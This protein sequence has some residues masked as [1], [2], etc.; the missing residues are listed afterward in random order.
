[1]NATQPLAA[2]VVHKYPALGHAQVVSAAH[3]VISHACSELYFSQENNNKNLQ[4]Q[5]CWNKL[6]TFMDSEQLFEMQ[7]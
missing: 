6:T 7:Q 3:L 4:V 2:D 5:A 1:M